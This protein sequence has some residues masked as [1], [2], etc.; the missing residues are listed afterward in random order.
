MLALAYSL[1]KLLDVLHTS[2]VPTMPVRQSYFALPCLAALALYAGYEMANLIRLV[3]A[4]R[5]Q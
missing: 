5:A 3:R 1:F 2:W 4:R